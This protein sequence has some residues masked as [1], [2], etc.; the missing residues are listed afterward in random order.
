MKRPIHALATIV[1][2]GLTVSACGSGGEPGKP[3]NA[4]P[5]TQQYDGAG[6]GGDPGGPGGAGGPG[7][8]GKVAAVTGSTAQVQGAGGQV[9]VTWNGK[10]TFTQQVTASAKDLEVGDCVAAMS[11]EESDTSDDTM[12]LTAVT[13]RISAAV[14]GACT[15]GMPGPGDGGRLEQR[16][17]P[18]G[19]PEDAPE[20]G[21]SG[22]VRRGGLG[23]F[24][25]VTSVDG[26]TF[27][28]ESARPGSDD[29]A[30]VTVTTSG[31]TAWTTAAKA[32]AKDVKV[33][34]CVVSLGRTDETGAVAAA[35]I[36]VSE[37]VDGQCAA[38][39]GGPGR[40]GGPGQDTEAQNS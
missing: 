39:P 3:G 4:G 35:S 22:P 27:T 18:G 26:N 16:L 15:N 6:P 24:G 38:M 5:V 20:G 23:A 33:G 1:A 11:A 2:L 21:D 36:A 34:R 13:V 25:K 30:T 10:T 9:A 32:T 19:A 29:T 8:S 14:N 7:G 17:P 31:D 40:P 28:V 12:K 37:P